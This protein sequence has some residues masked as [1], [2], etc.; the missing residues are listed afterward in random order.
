MPVTIRKSFAEDVSKWEFIV[1][2]DTPAVTRSGSLAL[3]AI[4]RDE[5]E[6]LAN[7]IHDL[8]AD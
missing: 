7:T 3:K 8:L 5:L 6:C 2:V 1:E 4:S